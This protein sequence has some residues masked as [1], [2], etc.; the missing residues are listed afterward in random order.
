MDQYAKNTV[1]ELLLTHTDYDY[2]ICNGIKLGGGYKPDIMYN[3]EIYWLD[4][5]G[6]NTTS[7]NEEYVLIGEVNEA[8]DNE[9]Q[10][11]NALIEAIDSKIYYSEKVNKI[12]IYNKEIKEY[13]NYK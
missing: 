8:C 11:T 2:D 7:I 10:V 1:Y 5:E 13:I 12:V 9:L 3:S 6:S 4:K